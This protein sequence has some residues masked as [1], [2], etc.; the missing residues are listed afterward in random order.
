M[1]HRRTFTAPLELIDVTWN[2]TLDEFEVFKAFFEEDLVNGSL[3]FEMTTPDFAPVHMDRSVTRMLG[4][5]GANYG[6]NRSDNLFTVTAILEIASEYHEDTNEPEPPSDLPELEVTYPPNPNNPDGPSCREDIIFTFTGLSPDSVYILE[7]AEVKAGPY[8]THI[9]FGLVGDEQF[10]GTKVMVVNNDYRGLRWFR[11]VRTATR[12]VGAEYVIISQPVKP[13]AS[14]IAPPVIQIANLTEFGLPEPTSFYGAGRYGV[15]FYKFD[16]RFEVYPISAFEDSLWNDTRYTRISNIFAGMIEIYG[17]G[18]NW[19]DLG[20]P[21]PDG[22]D[23]VLSEDNHVILT[24]SEESGSGAFATFTRDGTDPA[25][26]TEMPPLNGFE[27]NAFVNT[28]SFRGMIK[29]RAFEGVCRSPLAVVAVERLF[30]ELPFCTTYCRGADK[31][32]FCDLSGSILTGFAESGYSCIINFGGAGLYEDYLTNLSEGCADLVN[33]DGPPPRQ[34]F[35]AQPYPIL[36]HHH[37]PEIIDN[38]DYLGWTNHQVNSTAYNFVYSPTAEEVIAN[39]AAWEAAGNNPADYEYIQ[40][41]GFVWHR[42]NDTWEDYFPL[43]NIPVYEINTMPG[44]GS[45]IRYLDGGLDTTL[46]GHVDAMGGWDGSMSAVIAAKLTEVYNVR[47]WPDLLPPQIRDD[48]VLYRF[49][50]WQ[51]PLMDRVPAD[52][53]IG[54]IIAYTIGLPDPVPP[55]AGPPII[56]SVNQFVK[57]YAGDDMESYYDQ[58]YP[59]TN[60]GLLGG[61]F[62][63]W[64]WVIESIATGSGGDDFE[65]YALG[66]IP[67]NPS[68][69]DLPF[70]KGEMF[71]EA[72]TIELPTGDPTQD[73][74]ESY[75][76]G[77]VLRGEVYNGGSGFNGQWYLEE[78]SLGTDDMESY[79]DGSIPLLLQ[80]GSGWTANDGFIID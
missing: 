71:A 64:G 43:H 37:A 39:E 46:G 69:W 15:N 52:Y 20:G 13:M 62:W 77:P 11:Y 12:L 72:W 79:A 59:E 50:V 25:E 63:N 5:W 51:T 19:G 36:Y 75:T 54:V 70:D 74:F 76:D 1:R 2:F 53:W 65:A 8:Y 22:G 40:G 6:F 7:I 21:F 24:L 38:V 80:G 55:G 26:D 56:P 27:M 31:S 49:D 14:V 30:P 10:T 18:G 66:V 32:G 68:I 48:I 44:M 17:A 29:A 57:K 34:P 67:E 23:R 33:I 16:D 45:R 28:P 58:L 73:N 61:Y 4:F 3:L 9:Y 60:D 42:I 35:G 41:S 47:G 78:Y